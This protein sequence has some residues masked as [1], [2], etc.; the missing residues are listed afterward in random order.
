[1]IVTDFELLRAREDP[2]FRYQ[3][4]AATL[5]L[6]LRELDRLRRSTADAVRARQMREGVD[7]A[8]RLAELLQR[9]A[10][11]SPGASRLA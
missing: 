1:M 5:E 7:L 6:L 2:A 11:E 3:L 4:V 9:I 10:I 8:V